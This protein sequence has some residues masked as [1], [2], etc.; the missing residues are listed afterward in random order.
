MSADRGRGACTCC[1]TP[2]A[3]KG[4][5]TAGW[6]LSACSWH[7]CCLALVIIVPSVA[8]LDAAHHMGAGDT[9]VPCSRGQGSPESWPLESDSTRV[10]VTHAQQL[11]AAYVHTLHCCRCAPRD[12]AFAPHCLHHVF[13]RFCPFLLVPAGRMHMM[14]GYCHHHK[15]IS[16]T[17]PNCMVLLA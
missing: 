16:S 7:A 9:S 2:S 15:S 14:S 11:H 12:H 6:L 13:S 5:D 4:A 17:L 3:A 8:R 1:N 10:L